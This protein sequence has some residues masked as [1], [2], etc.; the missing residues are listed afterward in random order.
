VFNAQQIA[1]LRVQH[2]GALVIAHPECEEPVLALADYIGSTKGLLEFSQA[3]SATTF[4]VATEAGI[5]HQM[6]KADP[7]KTY[8]PAPTN[9]GCACNLCPHMKLNTLEKLYLCLRDL[10]NQIVMDEPLR[11]RALKPLQR[12][13]ELS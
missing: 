12:M 3:S 8:I 1:K 13:L 4:I 9:E 5:L 10:T 6:R 7:G 11:L 2:P